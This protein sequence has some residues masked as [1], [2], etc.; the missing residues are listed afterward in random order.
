M[1]KD[2]PAP[3]VLLRGVVTHPFLGRNVRCHQRFVVEKCGKKVRKS[4]WKGWTRM[5]HGAINTAVHSGQ[6]WLVVVSRCL[7]DKPCVL[8]KANQPHWSYWLHKV[9]T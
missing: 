8:A 3:A 5:R 7:L 6:V 2:R 1:I 4:D 9:H